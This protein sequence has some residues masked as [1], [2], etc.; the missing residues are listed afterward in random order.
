ME[1]FVLVPLS[2][3]DEKIRPSKKIW[4]IKPKTE[5][6]A[7]IDPTPIYKSVN[8]Q[9]KSKSGTSIV[10]QILESPRIKLSNSDTI[11]LDGRDTLV[12][13]VNFVHDL[14]RKTPQIPD[15]YF[16]IL[17]AT[18]ISRDLV[19]NPNAKKKDRGNWIPFQI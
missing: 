5:E 15:I 1:Q 7:P 2:V 6:K 17:D 16:T 4:D 11:I 9:L 19:N 13:I 12:H 18:Q 3:Y 10:D 8:R 14:R